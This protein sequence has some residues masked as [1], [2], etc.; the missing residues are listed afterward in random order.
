VFRLTASK[1]TMQAGAKEFPFQVQFG[2]KEPKPVVT[3]RVVVFDE[4]EEYTVEITGS[5]A[6]FQGRNWARRSH[7]TIPKFDG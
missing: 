4:T 5:T 3:L 7:A 2:P 1:G 6:G